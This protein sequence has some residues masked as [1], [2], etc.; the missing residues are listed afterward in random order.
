MR[1]DGRAAA[2]A[3]YEGKRLTKYGKTKKEAKEKLDAYLDDLKQGRV[4]I[5]PKQT[6]KQYLE[7]WLENSRRL[8]IRLSTLER[9]RTILRAHLIPAFGHLQLNQLSRERVQAYYAELF[10][11]GL[12]ASVIKNINMIL[13]SALKDA[14]FGRVLAQNVCEHVTLP[15]SNK[16]KP[17]VLTKEECKQLVDATRGHRIWFMILLALTTGARRGELLALQ[18]SDVDVGKRLLHIHRS[19]SYVN[20]I[21][22]VENEPKTA[23]GARQVRLTQIVIDSISEHQAH[24]DRMRKA[25]GARWREQGLV[26]P[27]RNGNYIRGHVVLATFRRALEKAGLPEMRFHDLRHSAATLLFA[28]GVNAKVVQEALGHSHV[29]ITLGMYG[30]VTPDMQQDAANAMDRVF[31]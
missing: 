31:E 21:G 13:S 19:M 25:A 29:S 9:Y 8:S 22:F 28:A 26:F 16:R 24:V 6:V 12:S 7:H 2:S 17:R 20:G 10:D 18:W 4:V 5:G 11:S 30:D 27:G 23:S 15:R 3:M 14:V 1:K